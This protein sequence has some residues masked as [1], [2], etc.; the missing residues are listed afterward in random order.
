[1]VLRGIIRRCQP[2]RLAAWIHFKFVN[3]HPFIDGNGR[4]AGLIMNLILMQHGY[5]PAVILHLDRKKYFR[6]LREVD[7]DKFDSYMEFIGRSIERSL[8]IYLQA[9]TPC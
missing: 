4:T 7:S 2:L 1:M 5:P 8:I 6:V 3:I 9:V